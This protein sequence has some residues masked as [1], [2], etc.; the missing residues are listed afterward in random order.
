MIP[1]DPEAIL[2]TRS[3]AILSWSWFAAPL[4]R[5]GAPLVQLDSRASGDVSQSV[6]HLW[7]L[8]GA[9]ADRQERVNFLI[10]RHVAE[11]DAFS[12]ERAPAPVRRKVAYLFQ[13]DP[14]IMA[15]GGTGI[16]ADLDR[17][18][19]DNIGASLH[20]PHMTIEELIAREPEVVIISG[21]PKDDA[22]RRV[23][24]N[25]ALRCTPAV[26]S[27]RVYREPHGGMRMEGL[28]EEPIM[29]QWMSEVIYPEWIE[30]RFRMKLR[31]AYAD[32]YGFGL[33]DDAI[34]EALVL[35]E[36]A[37]S[38]DYSRFLASNDAERR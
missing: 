2:L 10:R 26:R 24:D 19:A 21:Y 28:V 29:L 32:V 12:K 3:D 1:G 15:F 27:K 18:D 36:N 9:I 11:L 37:G 22:V 23:L 4:L 14:L 16:N 31:Q 35:Q 20:S 30:R 8:I 38:A 25:P 34:D 7:R 33:T 17:V 5:I 13:I 6:E